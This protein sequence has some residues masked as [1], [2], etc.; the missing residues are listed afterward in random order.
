MRSVRL[1][2]ILAVLL[3]LESAGQ[4]TIYFKRDHIVT[5]AGQEI[6][7]AEPQPQDQTAPAAPSNL[8]ATQITARSVQLS[9]SGSTD[10][11]GSGLAGY[12][13]YRGDPNRGSRARSHDVYGRYA[14][15]RN[16]VQLLLNT[17]F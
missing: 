14:P 5:P 2:V 3:G 4:Q 9:W 10:S 8:T 1:A 11:G 7:T 6:A 12:K 17:G 16:D 15:A 13:I